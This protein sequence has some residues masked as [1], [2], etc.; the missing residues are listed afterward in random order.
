MK[1]NSTKLLGILAIF[2]KLAIT[3]ANQ[4]ANEPEHNSGLMPHGNCVKEEDSLYLELYRDGSKKI[5]VSSMYRLLPPGPI[6]YL[7]HFKQ[8]K[9]AAIEAI[10]VPLALGLHRPQNI[11]K[12]INRS[13]EASTSQ[14][15]LMEEY[16]VSRFIEFSVNNIELPLSNILLGSCIIYT[17]R[18]VR[19]Q[20]G[21]SSS[22]PDIHK[23][24]AM[25]FQLPNLRDESFRK[26]CRQYMNSL[27]SSGRHNSPS[28]F[29]SQ[30]CSQI[31]SC[32]D[33]SA[34][35]NSIVNLRETL[36]INSEK[37]SNHDLPSRLEFIS[38]IGRRFQ[39]KSL[40]VNLLRL[41]RLICKLDSIL[42][43]FFSNKSADAFSIKDQSQ[44][45]S[46][47]QIVEYL[48]EKNSEYMKCEDLLRL[49][50]KAF[51]L[52]STQLNISKRNHLSK[53]LCS[54]SEQAIN[55]YLVP[56]AP[57]S[58]SFQYLMYLS[59]YLELPLELISKSQCVFFLSA[60][61]TGMFPRFEHSTELTI[62]LDQQSVS[63]K[64]N[65]YSYCIKNIPRYINLA[66]NTFIPKER[67]V[68]D[69]K[70]DSSELCRTIF[71]C[72]NSKSSLSEEDLTTLFVSII[73]S[74]NGEYYNQFFP[75]VKFITKIVEKNKENKDSKEDLNTSS[76]L[77]PPVSVINKAGKIHD[78]TVV[79]KVQ[80]LYSSLVRLGLLLTDQTSI[81]EVSRNKRPL[82]LPK[83]LISEKSV[84]DLVP[85]ISELSPIVANSFVP[86]DCALDIV[87]RYP[88]L[89]K[90]F[91][92]LS[93]LCE[94][95][96]DNS[97]PTP[98]SDI[99]YLLKLVNVLSDSYGF[100]I[101]KIKR[102]YAYA[103]SSY[104]ILGV[105]AR[106]L[107]LFSFVSRYSTINESYK[108]EY[109][110]CIENFQF[111]LV[112]TN[113][114]IQ[115][116]KES[117]CRYVSLVLEDDFFE[118]SILFAIKT[119]S[120]KSNTEEDWYNSLSDLF[121]NVKASMASS[122]GSNL[123]VGYTLGDGS[124]FFPFFISKY[125]RS[126]QKSN[127]FGE[128]TSE[129]I[130][131][132]FTRIYAN[133]ENIPDV[134]SSAFIG[135]SLRYEFINSKDSSK[136]MSNFK[137][138]SDEVYG[139][140]YFFSRETLLEH[141]PYLVESCV[142][143]TLEYLNSI[144]NKD[145]GVPKVKE[146]C[147]FT[148]STP[149]KELNS[150]LRNNALF[151][152][153]LVNYFS[154]PQG[155]ISQ[156]H[157]I[158]ELVNAFSNFSE[159][160][161][162]FETSIHFGINLYVLTVGYRNIKDNFGEKCK[163]AALLSN[164]LDTNAEATIYEEDAS[165]KTNFGLSLHKHNLTPINAKLISSLCNTAIQ[166]SKTGLHDKP[167]KDY[168]NKTIYNF[169]YED[170]LNGDPLDS[171]NISLN[172]S[173]KEY[174][175]RHQVKNKLERE[176]DRLIIEGVEITYYGKNVKIQGLRMLESIR[177][178]GVFHDS[179]R[180]LLKKLEGGD[181]VSQYNFS[182]LY[183]GSNPIKG[184][185]DSIDKLNIFS[186]ETAAYVVHQISI[187]ILENDKSF[188]TQGFVLSIQKNTIKYCIEHLKSVLSE[189]FNPYEIYSICAVSFSP[190]KY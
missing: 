120:K 58:I 159:G 172:D 40:N 136:D 158:Y 114:Q 98:F 92:T 144:G 111:K 65:F 35:L 44:L 96:I 97:Y 112:F 90:V 7:F 190:F 135:N 61:Y 5:N 67:I 103:A 115:K 63:N 180:N 6:K 29:I 164:I 83:E 174:S 71:G 123:T 138:V 178:F 86:S 23:V 132:I 186:I 146:I 102:I 80:K 27:S 156:L 46:W 152:N 175:L 182:G 82:T 91:F 185:N 131:Q 107:P 13:V 104:T 133:Y 74:Q 127:Y 8:S 64:E 128:L 25:T 10:N 3:Y 118:K 12:P 155:A 187:S 47:Q 165:S 147:E 51:P 78:P 130:V 33:D 124:K 108:S 168:I 94:N 99:P 126:L 137:P 143:T 73:S 20:L 163:I 76:K 188:E 19:N 167:I 177:L 151:I 32:V 30:V 9:T 62:L 95:V 43:T 166:C 41:Y 181:S 140:R 55:Q 129:G 21:I 18:S 57:T 75:R 84:D 87:K 105:Q 72:F 148:F 145:L 45:D 28:S 14:Q 37:L 149:N 31:Q 38:N 42:N 15:F 150:Q 79:I 36:S 26:V 122:I 34:I 66:E 68:I 121:N 88:E 100:S 70:R 109:N 59:E 77:L 189:T 173:N 142:S 106:L 93:S 48:D 101:N 85:S 69:I 22:L 24:A 11:S 125:I 39:G 170:H 117:F 157:C 54:S 154:I 1:F 81:S 119:Y 171:V 52:F 162:S 50:L 110:I 56:F 49:H 176:I 134:G 60:S 4:H 139:L 169:I 113:S 16:Y 161:P 184:R 116:N 141:Y 160:T 183:S 89:N 179:F 17:Y 153:Y 53:L 2:I